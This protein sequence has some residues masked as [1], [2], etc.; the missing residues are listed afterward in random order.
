VLLADQDGER[1]YESLL[2]SPEF[3]PAAPDLRI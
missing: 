2:D 3:D 1:T